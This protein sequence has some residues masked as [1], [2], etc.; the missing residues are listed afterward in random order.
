MN[1]GA[2]EAFAALIDKYRY[3]FCR[4]VYVI[5]P[6]GEPGEL[7]DKEPYDWQMKEWERLGAWLRNPETR[8]KPYR[9]A[10]S[11]GNGAAKTA[12]TA[13]TIIMLMYTQRVK[14]RITSNTEV[15]TRT[16]IWP[17]YDIWL[18]RARFND[19][20][21]VKT[22]TAIKAKDETLAES[23]KFD[24]FTWS[25]ESPA[26]IS[27]LHN[28]GGA[29][30]YVFEEAAGIPATV[31]KYASGAFTDENSIKL[32]FAMGNSD[33]PESA[34]EQKFTDPLW[35]SRR[36][37]T[38][39]LDH[40]SK[41]QIAAWLADCGGD[42]DHDD[43]RVRVRGLPR[44]SAK[45]SII[46]REM[47]DKAFARRK[48]FDFKSVESF[49]CVLTCDPAWTGGDETVIWMRQGNYAKLLE[50]YKLDKTSG[51]DH[52][53]TYNRLEYW[54][55]KLKADAVFIDQ[56]EGTAI[57]TLANANGKY[58][59][60][61]AFGGNANDAADFRDS[62]YRNMRAKMYYES[63]KWLQGAVLD[64]E[65]E[66]WVDDVKAQ[67]CW[68][69]G[70]RD[71]QHGKKMAEPKKDVKK[72]VGRSPDIADGFILG[73]YRLVSEKT[74]MGDWDVGSDALVIED[75]YNPYEDMDAGYY[76]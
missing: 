58:W 59:E 10:I 28:E 52:M 62:E 22:A 26:R 43:F 63:A 39:T 68:T 12:W 15:Q 46:S 19:L 37:D 42:E 56:G 75:E 40:I 3:D 60:L 13:M 50:R 48:D 23:W 35:H 27:G 54:E 9:L 16:V 41:D 24:T 1:K 4:L 14:G 38:R 8:H 18:R 47:V 25:E 67:L 49:P 45:D 31:W 64:C 61:V 71:K 55:R 57:F 2:V 20:W 53:F 74:G 7:L 36:I 11:S 32:W 65:E 66:E 5:F 34:F 29:V 76:N 33:D 44:K 69:K 51:Q 73:S 21:F 17:E 72:R 30:V 6:F 70:D